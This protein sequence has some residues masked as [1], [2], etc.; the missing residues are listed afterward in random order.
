MFNKGR[1]ID[2]LSE[3]NNVKFTSREIDILSV[4]LNNRGEK[5][6]ASLLSISPR[7]VSS[8]V[9]NIMLK[10]GQNSKDGIIDFLQRS[11]NINYFN[12]H[13]NNILRRDI[14]NK[15]LYKIRKEI[16]KNDIDFP[17]SNKD[18]KLLKPY[19]DDLKYIGINLVEEFESSLS[20]F[21]EILELDPM[22]DY[23]RK[24]FIIAEKITKKSK[25]SDLY[26]SFKQDTDQLLEANNFSEERIH[27]KKTKK[28]YII[29][30]SLITLIF[31]IFLFYNNSKSNISIARANL[32]LPHKNILIER[33]DIL[34]KMDNI[35]SS[36]NQISTVILAGPEGIGKTILARNYAK[37]QNRYIPIGEI[38]AS[39]NINMQ[40]S[41]EKL[42]YS[43][44]ESKED[45]EEI[46]FIEK[47]VNKKARAKK[48]E[49]FISKKTRKYPD[50]L[51]IY[52]NAASFENISDFFPHDNKVWGNGAIIITTRNANIKFDDYIPK[53]N[54][55]QITELT[56]NEKKQLFQNILQAKSLIKDEYFEELI[57]KIPSYPID[58]S[59]VANF[60]K[61]QQITCKEYLT[62]LM[63]D[64]DPKEARE[65]IVSKS[66]D[67][68]L[69]TNPGFE[70]L[71]ILANSIAN[72]NIPKKLFKFTDK[73]KAK[74]FLATLKKFAFINDK[75]SNGTSFSIP[76]SVQKTALANLKNRDFYKES[77]LKASRILKN[78][79]N[80]DLNQDNMEE[81]Q[82]IIPHIEA[83]LINTELYNS[84]E[85]AELYFKLAE[86]YFDI[87]S[88]EKTLLNYYNARKIYKQHYQNLHPKMA[89][90]NLRLGILHR[91]MGKYGEAKNY[92]EKALNS[93]KK[94]YPK[95]NVNLGKA[96]LY[97][98]S[99]YRNLPEADKAY[100]YT[101][102]G[103]EILK[104]S[105]NVPEI[106]FAKADSYL[107]TIYTDLGKY[108]L[109]KNMLE[110][111]L[112]KYKLYYND[113]HTKTA[114]IKIRLAIIYREIGNLEEAMQLI[115]EAKNTYRD[116]CGENSLE[117]AWSS[118]HLGIIKKHL[119]KI[120]EAN[121]LIYKSINIY[122][123]YYHAD[124]QT[125]TW[126]KEHITRT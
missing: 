89:H 107:G 111:T 54:I 116:Y 70:S 49:C 17:I 27:L 43:L 117:F 50:W 53:N 28:I 18:Y 113:N 20:S 48:L 73:D 99:I 124:H 105:N 121:K 34:T 8:H 67:H 14:F 93:Y 103:Y 41:F 118:T 36:N 91:N 63:D 16:L 4:I 39:S 106:E 66:I 62:Y 37:Y 92:L 30:A 52:N 122:K 110:N 55:I 38:D 47:V 45:R 65:Q 58:V 57:D 75:H 72:N 102:M 83:Y 61:E 98:G 24:F 82:F 59:H 42:A 19:L 71:L 76:H 15:S 100:H 114:W 22:E 33:H 79:I 87:G 3:V 29:I 109:A 9:H 35:L 7:T 32:M 21:K 68:I 81:V 11:G 95:N 120:T 46:E 51:L 123:S 1:E 12:S 10:T 101:K 112:K 115:D 31:I 119:G 69:E 104:T 86:C 25:I 90:L 74:S 5:K 23:H 2:E 80:L 13:Y 44:T 40:S 108:K 85:E 96:Y 97:L 94:I 64:H 56:R 60:I 126:A 6:I 88:Y 77:S 84:K 125:I 26:Q 78:Y